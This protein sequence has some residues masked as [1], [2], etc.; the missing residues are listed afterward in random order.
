M[1]QIVYYL[2]Y[3]KKKY[4]TGVQKTHFTAHKYI[5]NYCKLEMQIKLQLSKTKKVR[6]SKCIFSHPQMRIA[7][8]ATLQKI[9][10]KIKAVNLFI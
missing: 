8:Y 1:V 7:V 4:P 3:I 2:L 5:L 10:S 9:S 6:T